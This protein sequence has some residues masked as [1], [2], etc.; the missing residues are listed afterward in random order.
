MK[1]R[2]DQ[3]MVERGLCESRSR[4]QALILAGEVLVDGQKVKKAS[5]SVDEGQ[6]I[7]VAEQL[8]FVSRG[9][10]K[11][12]K[13]IEVFHIELKGAVCADIGASTGGFTDCMLQHGAKKVYAI[14]V[15]YGQ[16]DWKLRSDDRVVVRERTN[17]RFIVPGDFEESLD[18]AGID[19][20]FISLKLL[21]PPL[22]PCLMENGHVV[23]LV[24]PQFEAGKSQVGK[25]GVV[26]DPAVHKDVIQKTAEAA[27]KLGFS[28]P[29]LDF[30]PVTGPKGNME[31][32]LYLSKGAAAPD[33][34]DIASVVDRAHAALKTHE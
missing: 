15:G 11:L 16:L 5:Q 1:A 9:G 4:A 33:M 25:H 2:L 10:L 20:S 24:K 32:L 21:L 28:V 27:A 31:F 29:G 18:F 14:D 26:R 34:P 17:A 6:K 3:A 22:Y 19:A 7:E 30:S 12:Q 23:A 13:A 8:P